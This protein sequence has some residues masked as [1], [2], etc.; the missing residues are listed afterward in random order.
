MAGEKGE[1]QPSG[2]GHESGVRPAYLEARRYANA[3]EAAR[4][5]A[6]SQD[7]MRRDRNATNLS[8]YRLLVGPD[9][10][11]H[12]V[13]LGDTPHERLR[14]ELQ[15]AL[16]T[17]EPVELAIDVLEHLL[18]R[19]TAAKSMGSRVE[20]HYRPGSQVRLPHRRT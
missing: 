1:Q 12:V 13:I 9:L 17:G 20:R 19:R 7:R 2:P 3:E 16:S 8:V 11:S 10:D 15:T 18:Q 4:A 14:A 5:Y 6:E